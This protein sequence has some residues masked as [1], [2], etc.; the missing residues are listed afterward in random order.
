MR[1]TKKGNFQAWD[2]RYAP[3]QLLGENA[4]IKIESKEII[5]KKQTHK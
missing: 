4:L 1:I 2:P 3:K 5:A